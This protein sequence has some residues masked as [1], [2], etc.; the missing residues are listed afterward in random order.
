MRDDIAS[1]LGRELI[2]I[3]REDNP[4]EWD[5]IDVGADGAVSLHYS[6]RTMVAGTEETFPSVVL[7]SARLVSVIAAI[8]ERRL[9]LLAAG[10]ASLGNTKVFVPDGLLEG[11]W[12]VRSARTKP[13]SGNSYLVE[14]DPRTGLEVALP[15]YSRPRLASADETALEVQQATG[16]AGRPPKSRELLEAELIDRYGKGERHPSLAEWVRQLRRWL[17]NKH[18]TALLPG[19]SAA[20]NNLRRTLRRLEQQPPKPPPKIKV[21]GGK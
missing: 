3:A 8:R 6:H 21:S 20:E 5:R 10:D 15:V 9:R 11:D 16:T 2:E 7:P 18:P 14:V 13:R 19:Q 1:L 12:R 17:Q 4:G